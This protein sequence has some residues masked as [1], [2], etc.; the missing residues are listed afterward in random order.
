[1]IQVTKDEANYIRKHSDYVRIAI[2][3]KKK[4]SKRK[5]YFCEEGK[6][7]GDLLLEYKNNLKK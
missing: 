3:C 5:K 6:I 7:A 4:K 1:M 2:T